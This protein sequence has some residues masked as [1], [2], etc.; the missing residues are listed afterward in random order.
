MVIQFVSKILAFMLKQVLLATDKE[1][2]NLKLETS[3]GGF[4]ISS[5]ENKLVNLTSFCL[6]L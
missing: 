3:S 1:L 2:V 4:I 6:Q 5:I